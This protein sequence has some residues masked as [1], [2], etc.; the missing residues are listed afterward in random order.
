MEA[1]ARRL[2]ELMNRDSLNATALG[3]KTGVAQSTI[4]RWLNA[5]TKPE[6]ESI[7]KVASYFDV[8]AEYF[9]CKDEKKAKIYLM[10]HDMTSKELDE[11]LFHFQ[12][13]KLWKDSK[14]TA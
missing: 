11:S 12:K 7:E 9:I 5:V 14:R 1:M 8:P 10:L 2:V 13:E 3:K 6:L 4:N